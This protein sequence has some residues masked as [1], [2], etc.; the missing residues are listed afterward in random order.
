MAYVIRINGRPVEFDWEN[1]DRIFP[2]DEKVI[3]TLIPI[4]D[5]SEPGDVIEIID[6]GRQAK[7][8]EET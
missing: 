5:Q 1:A 2:E 6:I 8:E 7:P 3:E 4:L